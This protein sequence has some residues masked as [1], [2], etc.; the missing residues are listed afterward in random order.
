MFSLRLN[1]RKDN[2]V[3]EEDIAAGLN[4]VLVDKGHD[5]DVILGAV[6]RG[7]NRM[8]IVNELI[9]GA[10]MHGASTEIV[11]S[12]AFLLLSNGCKIYKKDAH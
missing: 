12:R 4:H 3:I 1:N 10:N 9:K 5:A 11:D 8:V 7:D 2:L 6:C